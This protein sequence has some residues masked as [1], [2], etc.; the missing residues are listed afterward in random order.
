MV[1]GGEPGAAH[2]PPG[3][4]MGLTDSHK[5]VVKEYFQQKADYWDEIYRL[6]ELA[7]RIHQL[8]HTRVLKL[9]RQLGLP[10]GT[11]ALVV[12]CGAGLGV[13]ALAQ[14]GYV[15]QGIDVVAEMVEQTRRRAVQAGVHNF[16]T[17][18]IGD[19]ERIPFQTN[20]F[21]LVLSIGVVPWLR[22]AE[23]AIREMSRVLQPGGYL[24][25]TADCRWSIR[26]MLDPWHNPVLAPIKNKFRNLLRESLLHKSSS[27]NPE[28]SQHSIKQFDACLRAAGLKK[29]EGKTIGF[30]PFSFFG[31]RFLPDSMGYR[32]HS[33]LQ[34]LADKGFLALRS[35]GNQYLVLAQKHTLTV[36][37]NRLITARAEN[38]GLQLPTP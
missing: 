27:N 11:Q 24:I 38:L 30:G 37:C 1:C 25:T 9:V 18:G 31:Y 3:R 8:R 35:A 21:G 20:T 4:T 13:I 14:N 15:V 32:I 26:R 36:S 33:E 2:P 5:R 23:M 19:V 34:D 29:I 6:P 22:S 28:S 16:V 10:T 7:G 12:G 17:A